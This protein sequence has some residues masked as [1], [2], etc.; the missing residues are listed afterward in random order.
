MHVTCLLQVHLLQHS[1]RAHRIRHHRHQC[2]LKAADVVRRHDVTDPLWL[3]HLQ[4]PVK[5]Q[6]TLTK[7]F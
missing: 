2:R 3:P 5:G 6:S 4:Q 1:C 7:Y